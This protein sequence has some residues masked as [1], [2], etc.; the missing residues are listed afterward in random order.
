MTKIR[1]GD[2]D[3]LYDLDESVRSVSTGT[4]KAMARQSALVGD[5]V[6]LDYLE[7]QR[8]RIADLQKDPAVTA[9]QL[10]TDIGY[11]DML[12]AQIFMCKRFAG[13][14]ITWAEAEGYGPNAI[15]QIGGDTPEVVE[16]PKD[17]AGISP[18]PDE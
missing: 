6:T 15:T 14:Q 9:L 3:T 13:E 10:G 7:R 2:D 16:A 12:T 8:V 17:G 11:L 4:I 1:I 18:E 5:A